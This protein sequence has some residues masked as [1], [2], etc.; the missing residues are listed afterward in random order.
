MRGLVVAV[1]LLTIAD[2]A[3]GIGGGGV[4]LEL[5][6]PR[7]GCGVNVDAMTYCDPGQFC[8]PLN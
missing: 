6:V 3:S 2:P 8:P 1:L 7:F 5:G 4:D